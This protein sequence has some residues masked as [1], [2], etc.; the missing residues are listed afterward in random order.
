MANKRT[1]RFIITNN[2]S[3]TISSGI[4]T[5]VSGEYTGVLG[6]TNGTDISVEDYLFANIGSG[7]GML[8]WRITS[9]TASTATTATVDLAL[10][11][12]V[13]DVT[14]IPDNAPI[15]FGSAAICEPEEPNGPS[16]VPSASQLQIPD[17]I[18]AYVN[19]TNA[20][21]ESGGLQLNGNQYDLDS[22]NV[23]GAERISGQGREI[24]F[25]DGFLIGFGGTDGGPFEV[26]A[27]TT[28]NSAAT[29]SQVENHAQLTQNPDGTHTLQVGAIS[30]AVGVAANPPSAMMLDVGTA[31]IGQ[32]IAFDLST[33][34]SAGDDATLTY[35]VDA[36]NSKSSAI[37]LDSTTGVGSINTTGLTAGDMCQIT[38]MVTD[39]AGFSASNTLQ[40]TQTTPVPSATLV[41]GSKSKSTL[42]QNVNITLQNTDG[43][44]TLAFFD[45]DGADIS[46]EFA[47]SGPASNG[48][49]SIPLT[50]VYQNTSLQNII[51][52]VTHPVLGNIG[53][54]VIPAIPPSGSPTHTNVQ[55][56]PLAGMTADLQINNIVVGEISVGPGNQH[57][58]G[59]ATNLN[60]LTNPLIGTPIQVDWMLNSLYDSFR[61]NLRDLDGLV[62]AQDALTLENVTTPGSEIVVTG[63]TGTFTESGT[64]PKT[65]VSTD[66]G[67][68]SNFDVFAECGK[69]NHIRATHFVVDAGGTG[70]TTTPGSIIFRLEISCEDAI[71]DA[72]N[73]ATTANPLTIA[74]I[75]DSVGADG[76]NR[77]TLSA[78]L[79]A[80]G[81]PHEFVGDNTDFGTTSATPTNAWG[82]ESFEFMRTGRTIDRGGTIG[83]R[84][85]PALNGVIAN[86]TPDILLCLG[87]NNDTNRPVSSWQPQLELLIDEMETLGV[88]VVF[89][90]IPQHDNTASNHQRPPEFA[91]NIPGMNAIIGPLIAQQPFIA[92]ADIN[93]V[94]LPSDL[95]T[96]GVHPTAGGQMKIGNT[97]ADVI[98]GV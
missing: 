7:V 45:S 20:F 36:A 27:G 91:D 6:S 43:T 29:L 93:A 54:V 31:V 80:A 35:S 92:L 34:S 72:L 71:A 64:N 38:F 83:V 53:S 26:G 19:Q 77:E 2:G 65:L 46:P 14:G 88:P 3:G 1:G 59:I 28:P 24:D 32:V 39:G 50:S 25:D 18:P 10:D 57:A 12:P 97:V 98:L 9:V 15:A 8:R 30:I 40:W 42:T 23:I 11:D 69:T 21:Y 17:S 70:S 78:R 41:L 51:A 47:A 55:G 87:G 79:T 95:T 68:E 84:E 44:E 89:G 76:V 66:T 62:A 86:F 60:V 5:G 94:I 90:N 4:V 48:L 49:L 74:S 96:D 13:A 22:R 61:L 37:T 73:S 67:N 56:T 58:T 81:I 82:G 16:S 63:G 85:E 33:V 75:G 52:S